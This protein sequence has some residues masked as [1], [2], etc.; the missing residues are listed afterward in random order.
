MEAISGIISS[1]THAAADVKA[2]PKI[3]RAGEQP[4]DSPITPE[5]DEYIPE[6]PR[7]PSGRYW[8]GRDT[9]GQPKV[10]FDNPEPAS[11][12]EAESCTCNTDKVDHEIEKLKK[13]REELEREIHAETDESKIRALEK[14]LAQVERELRQK[15]N[16][17]YRRQH[18]VFS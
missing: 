12:G 1:G 14:R 3:Q 9:D 8:L 4:Q 13:E 5:R 10:Y 2:P 18:A 16:D 15:D 11:D 17:A 6:E 7:E